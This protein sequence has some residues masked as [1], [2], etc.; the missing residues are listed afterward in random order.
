MG[1]TIAQMLEACCST[2]RLGFD[3]LYF[4]VIKVALEQGFL[5]VP[6]GVSPLRTIPPLLHLVTVSCGV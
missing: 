4:R 3:P 1:H 5:Q 2:Q 6:Y